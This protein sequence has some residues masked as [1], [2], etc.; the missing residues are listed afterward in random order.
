M[1]VRRTTLQHARCSRKRQRKI[2]LQ[3]WSE[4]APSRKRAAAGRRIFRRRQSLLRC[5][6]LA[7]GDEDA[8]KALE[9]LRCPYA[10]KDKRGNRG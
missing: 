10:I 5:A 8:K 1:A 2:T 9:R 6:L 7:L 3:H 4:W